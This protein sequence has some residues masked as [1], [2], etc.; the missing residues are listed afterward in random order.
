ML[1]IFLKMEKKK[2]QNRKRNGIRESKKTHRKYVPKTK[3]KLSKINNK[4]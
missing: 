4:N 2:Q 3:K 1:P